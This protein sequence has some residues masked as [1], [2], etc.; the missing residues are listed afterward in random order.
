MTTSV[1]TKARKKQ[2]PLS[3]AP[4][5]EDSTALFDP[6]LQALESICMR[7]LESRFATGRDDIDGLTWQQRFKNV[8]MPISLALREYKGPRRFHNHYR[9][10]A[11]DDSILHPVLENPLDML[12]HVCENALAACQKDLVGMY[13]DN[14]IRA[15]RILEQSLQSFLLRYRK[16]RGL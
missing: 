1:G 7:I 2:P 8:V 15:R 16:Y 4:D 13:A 12:A 11:D 3:Q 14:F 10:R 9:H 6:S 5:A